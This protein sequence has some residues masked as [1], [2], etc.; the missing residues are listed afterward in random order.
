MENWP[1]G[2]PAAPNCRRRSMCWPKRFFGHEDL[3]A[4]DVDGAQLPT[5]IGGP[6]A[7]WVRRPRQASDRARCP[8]SVPPIETW[9]PVPAMALSYRA[10]RVSCPSDLDVPLAERDRRTRQAA[11]RARYACVPHRARRSPLPIALSRRPRSMFCRKRSTRRAPAVSTASSLCTALLG[12]DDRGVV[13][14]LA[15]PGIKDAGLELILVAQ[16]A[17]GHLVHVVLAQKLG[18]QGGGA[19]LSG[20]LA[21]VLAHRELRTVSLTRLGPC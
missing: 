13:P 10:G 8:A 21:L 19:V 6:L 5:A 18:F 7:E 14:Q 12:E 2:L 1:R 9:Q 20:T 17:D 3:A 16:V 15:L 4:C 11:S